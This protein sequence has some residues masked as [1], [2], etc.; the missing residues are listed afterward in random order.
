MF[1]VEQTRKGLNQ[2]GIGSHDFFPGVFFGV[3][4]EA[5]HGNIGLG[6]LETETG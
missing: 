3:E 1:P 4:L 2:G 5:A 6:H